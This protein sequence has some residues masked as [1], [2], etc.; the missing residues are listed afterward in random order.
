MSFSR[1]II[2]PLIIITIAFSAC[3]DKQDRAKEA[4]EKAGELMKGQQNWNEAAKELLYSLSLQDDEKPTSLLVMTYQRLSRV[5]WEQDFKDKA[6]AYAL[7]GL[8]HAKQLDDEKLLCSSLNRAAA[9]YYTIGKRD[10]ARILYKES[11]AKVIVKHDTT[12]ILSCYNNL[13]AVAIDDKKYEEALT[14]FD[15]SVDY[16][17]GKNK[18]DQFLYHYN[19]SRC[20]EGM[21]HWDEC[22]V[23]IRKS[24][25]VVDTKDYEAQQKL[26]Q[27]LYNA[28]VYLGKTA[29]ACLCADS[30]FRYANAAFNFKQR[31]EMKHLTEQH[32]QE[33]YETELELQRTHWLLVVVNV[34]FIFAIVLVVI[35]YRN[36]KRVVNL[37]QRMESLKVK[38]VREEQKRDNP[39]EEEWTSEKE[40]NL[41][42]LYLEQFKVSRD[43]FRSRPT[44][45]KLRQ[46]KY[47]TDKSYLP[48][49]ERLPLIDGV[50]EVFL[51]QLQKLRAQY[52]ELTED[53]CLYAVL[54][55]VGCN[56]A[57]ASM[58]TKTS[59]ATLRKRRSRFKQKTTEQVFNV[60]MQ[61]E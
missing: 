36:K 14:Y 19:R 15:K 10:S 48:D 13:G 52:P 3:G 17:D 6:L 30:A 2:L 33:Q 34:V 58:L 61:G 24:L 42:Q 26:F 56:N 8:E 50:L 27:R 37:Q 49:E 60:L 7:K 45:N 54:I 29:D 40:E 25:D 28:N 41:E 39:Q 11:L 35:M 1:Y 51:D 23:E 5:Y 38:V 20:F 57:T 31:E 44:Y 59:E 18:K 53:E 16:K 55:F 46:L 4:C 22:A 43:I 9:C 12:A 32:Q 47:H 21:K